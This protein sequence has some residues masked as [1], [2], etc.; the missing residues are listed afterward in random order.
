MGQ[1]NR[2]MDDHEAARVEREWNVSSEKREL[3]AKQTE[4]KLRISMKTGGCSTYSVNPF[5]I[6]D[7]ARR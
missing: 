7:E 2:V 1:D 6:P 3:D 5:A 4:L